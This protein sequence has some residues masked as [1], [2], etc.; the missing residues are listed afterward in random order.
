MIKID[1]QYLLMKLG[2]INVCQVVV[3]NPNKEDIIF[4]VRSTGSK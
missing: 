3:H 4:K 1:E 2:E